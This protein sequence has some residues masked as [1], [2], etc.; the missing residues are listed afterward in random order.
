M[1]VDALQIMDLSSMGLETQIPTGASPH[2]PLFTPN[3]KLGLVD[4][5][6]KAT[7]PVGSAP[8]KIVVRPSAASAV[9]PFITGTLTVQP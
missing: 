1:S 9:H 8:R 2:H 7:V 3:G 6:V 4:R 5:S